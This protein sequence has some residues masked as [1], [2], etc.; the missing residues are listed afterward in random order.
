MPIN[1]V[2]VS[3]VSLSC[4][5][6]YF[7]TV[8]SLQVRTTLTLSCCLCH[9]VLMTNRLST[10]VVTCKLRYPPH[11]PPTKPPPP[12]VKN[13]VALVV[14]LLGSVRTTVQVRILKK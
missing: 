11:L 3:Q 14:A 13:L 2:S 6:L 10:F 5:N 8:L 7:I 12:A 4:A 9:D 1:Y